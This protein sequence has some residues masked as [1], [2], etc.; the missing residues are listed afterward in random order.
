MRSPRHALARV[1]RGVRPAAAARPGGSEESAEA[2]VRRALEYVRAVEASDP[3]LPTPGRPSPFV[4]AGRAARRAGWTAASDDPVPREVREVRDD[5]VVIESS[6]AAD[7]AVVAKFDL[8]GQPKVRAFYP[9]AGI[10]VSAQPVVADRSGI[11]RSVR[12]HEVVHEVAPTFIPE[13]LSHGAGPGG[14]PYLVERAVAG[15]PLRTSAALA[16]ALPLIVDGLARVHERYGVQESTP[17]ALWGPRIVKDWGGLRGVLAI[18]DGE[19]QRVDRLLRSHRALGVSWA[20]GDLVA[21]NVLGTPSGVTLVDWEHSEETA[22]MMDAAKLHLFTADPEAA[23]ELLLPTFGAKGARAAQVRLQPGEELALAH[24]RYL[25][26][27][28]RRRAAL[29]GHPRQKFYD[30][31]VRR[32]AKR[33]SAALAHAV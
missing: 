17:R 19:W 5:A 10:T 28:R 26:R 11:A 25:S 22:V 4:V 13:L 12:A 9:A 14:T 31:Q 7:A 30:R 23:L 24:A 8:G 6:V 18:T 33:L 32:Q 29:D 27:Y 3:E 16:D 15:T 1:V 21:T 20:H 2:R